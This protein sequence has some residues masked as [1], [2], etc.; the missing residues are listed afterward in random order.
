MALCLF[1]QHRRDTY[2]L[3]CHA[4][5][6]LVPIIYR[7]YLELLPL[8]QQG[9]FSIAKNANFT[10]NKTLIMQ[11]LTIKIAD[12]KVLLVLEYLAASGA[13]QIDKP[14]KAIKQ[15]IPLSQQLAGSISKKQALNM[16]IEL[17]QMRS[18]WDRTI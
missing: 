14:P 4:T 16:E 13:I 9:L 10:F 2:R 17:K 18:E 11:T 8:R 1:M 5:G 15:S 7:Y 6:L 3:S 12:D